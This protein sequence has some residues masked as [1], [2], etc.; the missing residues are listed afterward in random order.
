MGVLVKVMFDKYGDSLPS[1]AS[2][3]LLVV[4]CVYVAGGC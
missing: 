3:G 2:W 1:P 4:I